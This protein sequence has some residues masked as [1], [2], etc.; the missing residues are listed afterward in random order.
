MTDRQDSPFDDS[1]NDPDYSPSEVDEPMTS[2]SVEEENREPCK[3]KKR[4]REPLKWKRNVKKELVNTGQKYLSAGGITKRKKELQPPCTEKCRLKCSQNIDEESRLQIFNS[5]YKC[6]DKN[7]QRSFINSCI[8][9]IK[10]RKYRNPKPGSKRCLNY[11]YNLRLDGKKV[12]VCKAFFKATLDLSN[13]AIA[14]AIAKKTEVGIV[15][16]DRRGSHNNHKKLDER[17]REGVISHINSFA[18]IESHYCRKDNQREFIDGGLTI[19]EMYR[20]YVEGCVQNG[21][22]TVKSH[23]YAHIFNTNFNI[24][25]FRPKKDLCVLCDEYEHAT[26]KS[27]LSEKYNLHQLEKEISRKEKADDIQYSSLHKDANVVYCFDLQAVIPLPCGNVSSFYYKSKL[28]C[29][30]FTVFNLVDKRGLCYLWHEGEARR[31]CNEISTCIYQLLINE[32]LGKNVTFYSDNCGGQN[33][34]R[35][36]AVMY[37][38]VIRKY[39][40]QSINHKFLIV[41]HTQNEGDSMH[42]CIESAKKRALLSGPLFTPQQI[43][44]LIKL[45]KKTGQPYLV[46]DLRFS[47]I[48]DWKTLSDNFGSFTKNSDGEKVM[49]SNIKVLRVTKDDPDTLFYKETFNTN[50]F[51]K[52]NVFLKTKNHT[53]VQAYLEAPKIPY[54]KKEDLLSLLKHIPIEYQDFF[55]NLKALKKGQ[56]VKEDSD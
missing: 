37:L 1:D 49:W 20:L 35:F 3:P 54:K 19:S 33:K 55:K 27:L 45:A 17:L 28:N 32:C 16:P 25:F 14:T 7:T 10:E 11:S 22:P 2:S 18:R 52:I 6:G 34:N 5:Y 38:Y 46:K 4:K 23:M 48:L 47:D 26:D 40:I 39:D 15:L 51:K 12:K 30:N 9:P 24:G 29:F 8:T 50:V 53:P 43:S 13:T 42:A 41:G 56:N 21:K 31:G 36:M 44:M